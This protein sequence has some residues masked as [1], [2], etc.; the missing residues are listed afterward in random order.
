MAE[1]YA[2]SSRNPRR[3]CVLRWRRFAEATSPTSTRTARAVSEISE[4]LPGEKTYDVS[5]IFLRFRPRTV[6]DSR[7]SIR[8]PHHTEP[9]TV[10]LR[11]HAFC[12][13]PR[14]RVQQND[15]YYF[16][17][18]RADSAGSSNSSR[19]FSRNVA[20]VFTAVNAAIAAFHHTP[21]VRIDE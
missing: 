8:L 5:A 12:E 10:N 6:G 14:H 21:S 4:W 13:I 17:R 3:G 20:H 11:Q 7:T 9:L 19:R 16:L 15:G 18:R 2:T 1:D